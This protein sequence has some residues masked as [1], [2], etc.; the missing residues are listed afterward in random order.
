MKATIWLRTVLQSQTYEIA[1]RSVPGKQ[2]L[3]Q[4]TQ[5]AKW[6]LGTGKVLRCEESLRK[7]TADEPSTQDHCC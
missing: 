2:M 6:S 1:Q 5:A 4:S 3:F 7:Q